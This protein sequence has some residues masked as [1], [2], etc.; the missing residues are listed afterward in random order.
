MN[1]LILAGFSIFIYLSTV[2]FF[3]GIH[4]ENC[5]ARDNSMADKTFPVLSAKHLL[6]PANQAFQSFLQIYWRPLALFGV[7]FLGI[8]GFFIEH[9]CNYQ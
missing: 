4:R 2:G 8:F 5:S 6:S 9:V 7:L 3:W 1:E